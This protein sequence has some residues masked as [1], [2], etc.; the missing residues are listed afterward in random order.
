MCC[1]SKKWA[2]SAICMLSL[3]AIWGAGGCGPVTYVHQVVVRAESSVAAAKTHETAKHAPYEYYGAVAYLKEARARAGYG[4][5]QVA[6]KYGEKSE[7]MAKKAIRL[8]KE[9]LAERED[10]GEE[11]PT[12]SADEEGSGGG[13]D[14]TPREV[15]EPPSR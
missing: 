4:D 13:G 10:V 11:A 1:H 6:V 7:K 8:T 5:F 12:L 2:R 14:S 9:R 3:V 15:P